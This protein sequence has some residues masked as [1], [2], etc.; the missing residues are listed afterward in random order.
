MLRRTGIDRNVINTC[1]QGI[2]FYSP[3]VIMPDH[4]WM[5]IA[6]Q[7]EVEITPKRDPKN[8][9]GRRNKDL[10][11]PKLHPSLWG[12]DRHNHGNFDNKGGVICDVP[13]VPVYRTYIWCHGHFSYKYFHPRIH[14]KVP[15]GKMIGCK[16]CRCRFINM[17]TDDD[18]DEDWEKEME[19]I[20]LTP[21]S[22]KDLMRPF[23][24][25]GGVWPAN[26]TNFINEPDPHV[27][28]VVFDPMKHYYD[29]YKITPPEHI[30]A[31]IEAEKDIPMREAWK[32]EAT[33][34]KALA[35]P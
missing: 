32:P 27:Y 29:K 13:P 14:I 19:E 26:D 18:N 6:N 16:W 2:T 5:R 12:L 34:P 21:E 17:S 23:R 7:K 15:R 30:R 22:K 35:R 24:T 33:W 8:Y 9:F 11:G 4:Y 1:L 28:R 3:M 20:Q 31:R 25:Q 10:L